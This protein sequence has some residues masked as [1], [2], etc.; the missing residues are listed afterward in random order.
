MDKIIKWPLLS[1]SI[2]VPSKTT[3]FFLCEPFTVTCFLFA[4]FII[5]P[6]PFFTGFGFCEYSDPDSTLRALR[7]LNHLKMGEKTL[8]VCI[9]FTV[10]VYSFY[11][12]I[13][14]AQAKVDAKTRKD[15]LKYLIMKKLT[16]E[17]KEV[18]EEEVLLWH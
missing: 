8:V 3:N 2:A 10:V 5:F 4:I 14:C 18:K 15:L 16:I 11:F 7:L 6:S 9:Y 13:F 17:S 12:P 1:L